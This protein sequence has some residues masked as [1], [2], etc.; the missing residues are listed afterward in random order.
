[1]RTIRN[2]FF[3]FFLFLLIGSCSKND[4][5]SFQF[6]QEDSG[7]FL[8][9]DQNFQNVKLQNTLLY[10]KGETSSQ[11]PKISDQKYLP[12]KEF[13]ASTKLER[14]DTIWIYF[15]VRKETPEKF[16][17]YFVEPEISLDFL[18]LYTFK[19]GKLF[20]EFHAGTNFPATERVLRY[21]FYI[22]E[23][24]LDPGKNVYEFYAK[25]PYRNSTPTFI[26]GNSEIF[27]EAIKHSLFSTGIYYGLLIFPILMNL[28]LF[29][30][31]RDKGLLFY[32]L[33]LISM[34]IHTLR[35][36][37]TL[38]SIFLPEIP[39][40]KTAELSVF[41]K[42]VVLFFT[43]FARELLELKTVWK[44]GYKLLNFFAA[45]IFLLIVIQ[46]GLLQF[47]P[48]SQLNYFLLTSFYV[49]LTFFLTFTALAIYK[50]LPRFP[51]FILLWSPILIGG[52]VSTLTAVR[53]LPLNILTENSIKIGN[54]IEI[55]ILSVIMAGYFGNEAKE[56]RN[57]ERR[58]LILESEIS[59]AR[60][61]QESLLPSTSPKQDTL[62]IEFHYS[63]MMEVGGDFI[64]FIQTETGIGVLI[65]DVSGHGLSAAMISSSLK[66]AFSREI[67]YY[68]N[69][70]E[71]VR[72]IN[73][74][75]YGKMG[76]QFLTL[77]YTFFN[78]KQKTVVNSVGGH[79]P[80]YHIRKTGSEQIALYK[81]EARGS[82]IGLLPNLN[83]K[84]WETQ[85]VKGD[86][87]LFYT[88][89]LSERKNE[90]KVLFDETEFESVLSH[91]GVWETKDF[92]RNLLEENNRFANH[93]EKDDDIAFIFIEVV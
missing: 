4:E 29:F 90:K 73:S 91:S 42:F 54:S 15:Q 12:E 35:I 23:L 19:D 69:P 79:P 30:S 14:G 9:L 37:G 44:T 1:M 47:M 59:T 61:I 24:N 43:L 40:A 88:D 8:Q 92:V 70:K 85:F 81:S 66:L 13:F 67:A 45:V 38:S 49:E 25:L 39:Q 41:G 31:V 50:K 82:L 52:L 3:L 55:L 22:H 33:Y 84:E 20:S 74:A 53:I 2:I 17:L 80:F 56:K 83:P 51:Y 28:I 34:A 58:L 27:H 87:F 64:D 93:K 6:G 75:M 60:K 89:G 21:P 18:Y 32:S 78:L 46:V 68:E 36:E 86:R 26:L 11:I 71:L 76:K 7:S 77:S 72:A 10:W 63:P 57:S 16:L 48:Y 62:H 5:V 65:A